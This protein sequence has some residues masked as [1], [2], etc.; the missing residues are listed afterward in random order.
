MGSFIKLLYLISAVLFKTLAQQ[1]QSFESCPVTCLLSADKELNCTSSPGVNFTADVSCQKDLINDRFIIGNRSSIRRISPG[2]LRDLGTCEFD[3]PLS[4]FLNMN[5][6]ELNTTS[7]AGLEGVLGSLEVL[8]VNTLHPDTLLHHRKITSLTFDSD[9]TPQLPDL[10]KEKANIPTFLRLQPQDPSM[11]IEVNMEVRCHK[12]AGE[13]PIQ[14]SAIL[15]FADIRGAAKSGGTLDA[16]NM[17]YMDNCPTLI[18]ALG[19]PK[20]GSLDDYITYG[21]ASSGWELPPEVT[22][23]IAVKEAG[24]TI[25]MK[26]LMLSMIIWCTVLTILL[27]CLIVALIIRRRIRAKKWEME[28]RNAALQH[29]CSATSLKHIICGTSSCEELHRASLSNGGT[30]VYGTPS[31]NSCSNLLSETR[32]QYSFR[33]PPFPGLGYPHFHGSV[34]STEMPPGYRASI[35]DFFTLTQRN[36]P[37]LMNGDAFLMNGDPGLPPLPT[38]PRFRVPGT[39]SYKR[40]HDGTFRLVQS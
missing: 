2:G 17:I 6:L 10:I 11:P 30:W 22:D 40:S 34:Y 38:S 16:L 20:N 14:E 18:N 19:C 15:T 4:I 23:E 24:G 37:S 3:G 9:R 12:C 26:P 28:R 36:R 13:Q 29:R 21:N 25:R 5:I 8:Q 7:F 31:Q 27:I 33:P 1:S 32:S 35:P 39:P